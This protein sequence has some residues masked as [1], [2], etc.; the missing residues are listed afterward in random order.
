MSTDLDYTQ[1]ILGLYAGY[2][3]KIKKWSGKVGARLESTW[4]DGRTTNHD[5]EGGTQETRFDNDFFNVVPYVTLS[6]QPREMQTV[7]LSYTQRLSRPGIWQLNPFKDTHPMQVT[8]GNPNLDSEISHTFSL[9]YTLFNCHGHEPGRRTETAACRTTVSSM[10]I[11][12]DE[13]GIA[14]VTYDNI[15][16]ARECKLNV[17]FSGNVLPTLN[18]YTNL[19]GG[20]GDYSSKQAGYS[21]KGWDYNG[22]P[23]CPLECLERRCHQCQPGLLLGIPHAGGNHAPF[24]FCGFSVSQSFFNKRLQLTLSGQRPLLERA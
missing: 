2:V 20:Y 4:N 22:F 9:G 14:N 24:A 6:W 12:M 16:R 21:N 8:Y 1:H 18:L 3:L 19:S 13:N 17:F 5:T 23:G 10:T 11:F 7:K 15:G